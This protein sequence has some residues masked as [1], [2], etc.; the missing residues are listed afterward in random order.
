M[1][2]G[3]LVPWPVVE[4]GPPGLAAWS[5]NHLGRQG[6][7]KAQLLWNQGLCVPSG[8]RCLSEEGCRRHLYSVGVAHQQQC[9]SWLVLGMRTAPGLFL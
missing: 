4:P 3:I 2:H 5:P 1:A 6:S 8:L 7:P 9:L